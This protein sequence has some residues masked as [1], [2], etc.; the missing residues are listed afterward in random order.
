M[1]L[2]GRIVLCLFAV[3][4]VSAALS[5]DASGQFKSKA[6]SQQ[7]NDDK[8]TGKDTVDVLFSLKEY[9]GG[10]NHKNTLKIGTAFAGSAVFIGG[11]QMYNEQYWKL[12]IAYAGIGAGVAGGIYC[13]A[14]GMN[15]KSKYWFIGAGAVYWA[16][17]MDGILNYKPSEFPH[18]GKATLFSIMLPGLGQIYNNEWWKLPIY[19]GGMGFAVHLYIDNKA[20]FNRFQQLYYDINDGTYT[21]SVTSEQA[22]YYRSV[23][24]RY[25]DYSLL[26]IFGVYLLQVIDANVFAYMHDF[27]IDENLAMRVEPTVIIPDN[28]LASSVSPAVGLRMGFSF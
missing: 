19:L 18:P 25:R 12:P 9:F 6:F 24:R 13:N 23:Y 2:Y 8:S 3:A 15:D 22:L 26:A 5:P 28:Q 16:T 11:M 17:L 21:G 7:Y 27:D 4:T 10:L 1:R 14:N 20:N